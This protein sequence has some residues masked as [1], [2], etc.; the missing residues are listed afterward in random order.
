MKRITKKGSRTASPPAAL[1]VIQLTRVSMGWIVLVIAGL[2]DNKWGQ[3]TLF[4]GRPIF[5][6]LTLRPECRLFC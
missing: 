6:D 4:F 3:M 5:P 2:F 1:G